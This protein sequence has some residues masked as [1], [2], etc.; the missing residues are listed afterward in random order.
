MKEE[1][2]GKIIEDFAWDI[3]DLHE[4]WSKKKIDAKTAMEKIANLCF[5]F[6]RQATDDA[7]KK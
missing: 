1:Q 5:F 7:I 4:N 6:L 2:M 3:N